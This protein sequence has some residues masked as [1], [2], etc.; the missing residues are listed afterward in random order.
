MG[1]K[2]PP[3]LGSNPP[4]GSAPHQSSLAEKSPVVVVESLEEQEQVAKRG[5][6][7]QEQMEQIKKV[8]ALQP[9]DSQ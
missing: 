3:A 4:P 2:N 6:F 8:F 1:Q 5:G 9:A 7:T